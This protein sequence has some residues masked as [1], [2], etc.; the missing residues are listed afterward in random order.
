LNFEISKSA[1]LN[2]EGKR[3]LIFATSGDFDIKLAMLCL[4]DNFEL[5]PI[6]EL[7]K[8]HQSKLLFKFFC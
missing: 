8:I 1:Y 2:E 4:E 6:Q 3:Y 7:Q 5:K